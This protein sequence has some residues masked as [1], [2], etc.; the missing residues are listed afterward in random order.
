MPTPGLCTA[1]LRQLHP[2]RLYEVLL[3]LCGELVTFTDESRLPREFTPYDHD[4][5]VGCFSPLMQILRQALSTVL[6][7]R[8]L[9]IALQQRQYGLTVAPVQDGQLIRDA[10]FILAVKADMPLTT[11][12]NSLC[13]SARW[14][15]R[16]IR[17]LISLAAWHSAVRLA[18]GT[19]P[20]AVSAGSCTSA[21]RPE[22][23]LADAGQ[24]QWIC[25]PRGGQL[26]GAGDAILGNQELN[27]GRCT[28]NGQTRQHQGFR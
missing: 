14:P 10:E 25:L 28:G 18:G 23:G 27:H 9:S 17:D 11:C 26:P 19:A 13:S 24:R 8:A 6:E 2:E 3:E 12:A 4:L 22:P 7:P 15:R 20:V 21:G 5:P 16:K 1:R